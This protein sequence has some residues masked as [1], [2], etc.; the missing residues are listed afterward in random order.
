MSIL[1]FGW[2]VGVKMWCC[3]GEKDGVGWDGMEEN[4]LDD[5]QESGGGR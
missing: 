1:G 4:G 2:E 3:E 5:G